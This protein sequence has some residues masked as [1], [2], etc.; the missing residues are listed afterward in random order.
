MR[1]SFSQQ[2]CVRHLC[3]GLYSMAFCQYS[4]AI[5]AQSPLQDPV[6]SAFVPP[7]SGSASTERSRIQEA[8][9]NSDLDLKDYNKFQTAGIWVLIQI[10]FRIWSVSNDYGPETLKNKY[11]LLLLR[12][13]QIC[14]PFHY[15]TQI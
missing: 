11:F 14:R 5:P 6:F 13:L 1:S 9:Q 4:P 3:L 10:L 2:F 7:R 15:P 8:P 12:R